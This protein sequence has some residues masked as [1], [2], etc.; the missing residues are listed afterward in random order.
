MA[1]PRRRAQQ[2]RRG[3]C[4]GA[5]E[6]QRQDPPQGLSVRALRPSPLRITPRKR[7]SLRGPRP[8]RRLSVKPILLRF[9][10]PWPGRRGV[11][12]VPCHGVPQ[13]STPPEPTLQIGA[14][15]R[16]TTPITLDISGRVAQGFLRATDSATPVKTPTSYGAKRLVHRPCHRCN[17][18]LLNGVTGSADWLL[19]LRYLAHSRHRQRA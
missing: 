9:A 13:P 16:G 10:E 2:T 15:K 6:E 4:G 14:L 7:P 17:S 19:T 8:R 1:S 18:A 5:R 12:A 11:P 3:A